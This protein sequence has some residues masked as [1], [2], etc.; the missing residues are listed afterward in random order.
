MQA[1]MQAAMQAPV[2]D[3]CCE[4]AVGLLLADACG[5]RQTAVQ[6]A[7]ASFGRRRRVLCRLVCRVVARSGKGAVQ[8]AVHD[9]CRG[10]AKV[11][12]EV[13]QRCCAG[14]SAGCCGWCDAA[15]AQGAVAKPSKG[16]AQAAVQSARPLHCKDY[17]RHILDC[18]L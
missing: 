12:G 10:L 7:V 3:S 15:A 9:S 16:A 11:P 8:A 5:A 14:C 18:A 1:A 4:A 17:V 2:A 13:W 6:S